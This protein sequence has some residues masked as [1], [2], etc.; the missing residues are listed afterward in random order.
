M[1]HYCTAFGVQVLPLKKAKSII[2][3]SRIQKSVL[4][5]LETVV[6]FPCVMA[7]VLCFLRR[8]N[9]NLLKRKLKGGFSL[10][11]QSTYWKSQFETL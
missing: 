2:S 10:K 4:Q 9:S 6:G 5:R 8:M 3:A 7:I 1:V 11:L